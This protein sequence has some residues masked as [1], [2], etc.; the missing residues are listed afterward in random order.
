[1][2]VSVHSGHDGSQSTTELGSAARAAHLAS[3]LQAL[4][5]SGLHQHHGCD[6]EEH[7]DAMSPLLRSIFISGAAV[8][9]V[10]VAA[11]SAAAKRYRA[12]CADLFND[13]DVLLTLAASGEAPRRPAD[14]STGSALFCMLW[15]LVGVPVVTL[16]WCTGPRGLPLAV[17]L[18]G[19]LGGDEELLR[20]A[21]ALSALSPWQP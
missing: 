8:P 21:D 19:P 9:P 4:M 17:Q 10:G 20:S 1:M 7:A 6:H 3:R 16:P 12:A 13:C 18:A 2:T 5:R 14:G 11:A 15:T